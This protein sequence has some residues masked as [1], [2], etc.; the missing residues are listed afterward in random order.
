MPKLM[1]ATRVSY[2]D[3]EYAI[4]PFPAMVSTRIAGDLA[5]YIGPI[6]SALMPL[7]SGDLKGTNADEVGMEILDNAMKRQVDELVPV[8]QSAFSALDGESLQ[9]VVKSLL[10]ENGNINY[11]YVDDNG[12]VIT[13]RLTASTMDEL[14]IG[15]LDVMLK[16][17][18]DVVRVNFTGFFG[19]RL[20]RSGG[21]QGKSKGQK[22]ASTERLMDVVSVL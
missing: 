8:L 3:V 21:Q 10:I 15:N 4:F 13:R 11:E 2:N 16:L 12:R 7:M 22:S 5:K 18:I 20:S 6:V 1:E 19:S 9:K 14:F 17:C